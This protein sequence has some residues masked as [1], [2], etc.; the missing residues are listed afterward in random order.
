[1]P[2][3]DT[4]H[5]AAARLDAVLTGSRVGGVGGSH[6]EVVHHGRRIA[7]R[8]VT[9]VSA[10]GKHL[11]VA[12]DNGWML[13]THLGMPGAWHVYRAGERWRRSP[14]AARVVLD[15]GE[16]VAVCF[17]APTVQIAPEA[18]V[19]R[20]IAH[21]GPDSASPDFD[22]AEAARRAAALP[23][24]APVADTLLD[25]GVLAGVGNVFKSEILFAERLH[26]LTPIGGLDEAA[27][28]L[29]VE[30][31]ARLLAANR[32]RPRRLTTGV[33]RPGRRLWVYQRAG[34]PCRR[35][36]ASIAAAW[37][38]TPPR[39]TFWCPSCQPE[40]ART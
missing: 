30:R 26:P 8:T 10:A 32:E 36:A 19:R 27:L 20:A 37:L 1:M 38:G 33:D 39:I 24:A 35:C 14:G 16:A 18:L 4:I 28:R 3:G 5:R 29:L 22:L 7:G 12:F 9:A 25:Q 6:R 11:L 13:R 40:P 31:A 23:P 15:T 17:A 2:E 21:L 34:E